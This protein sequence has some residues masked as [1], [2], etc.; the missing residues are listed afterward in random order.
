MKVNP[1]LKGRME[2]AMGFT[3]GT[4]T[5]FVSDALKFYINYIEDHKLYIT[6]KDENSDFEE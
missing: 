3:G 5:E 6:K 2:R 4:T 1:S